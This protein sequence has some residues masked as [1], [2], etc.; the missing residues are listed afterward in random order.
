MYILRKAIKGE[1]NQIVQLIDRVRSG[2]NFEVNLE[3]TDH[4]LVDISQSYFNNR[5]WF[6]VIEFKGLLIGTYGLILKSPTT[7]ELRKMYLLP[8]YQS[9]GLGK[10]MMEDALKNATELGYKEMLLE[11]NK[12]LTTA[13]GLYRKFGFEELHCGG[14]SGHCDFAMRKKIDKVHK[15]SLQ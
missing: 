5:G 12:I 15:T 14:L 9:K 6:S 10:L 7:C 3:E 8:E 4:D 2:Y 11:T 1:E 13:I